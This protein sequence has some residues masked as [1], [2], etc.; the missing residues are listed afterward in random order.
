MNVSK[1][2]FVKLLDAIERQNHFYRQTETILENLGWGEVIHPDGYN[3]L[4]NAVLDCLSLE[5]G[6][7]SHMIEYCLYEKDF[8]KDIKRTDI[9]RVEN[10]EKGIA[11]LGPR[12]LWQYL[13]GDYS[14]C[15]NERADPKL[16]SFLAEDFITED[17]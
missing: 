10:P 6:D 1:E 14:Y 13:S 3:V 17:R 11:P 9:T 12:E 16:D 2:L 5:M 7:Y 4:E 15:E 8:F